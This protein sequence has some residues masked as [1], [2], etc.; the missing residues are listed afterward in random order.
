LNE[1]LLAATRGWWEWV[2]SV[3]LQAA[4]LCLIVAAVDRV[5]ARRAWPQL[6]AALWLTVILKLAVPPALVPSVTPPA[7][8][9]PGFLP[10]SDPGA[11]GPGV[12]LALF[13]LWILGAGISGL[14]CAWRWRGLQSRWLTPAPEPTPTWLAALA[15]ETAARLG[16][17]RTPDLRVERHAPGPAVVGFVRPVI[18]L[19]ARDVHRR[20]REDVRHALLHELAH[21][22]RRDPLLTLILLVAQSAFWF[23]PAVW[24]ARRRLG[25]L[26]E[27]ACDQL[28][29][30]ALG[31]TA[32]ARYRRTLLT[33][34]RP[35]L[36][37]PGG[38]L[39]FIRRRSELLERLRWLER[40]PAKPSRTR[41]PATVI[42][43]GLLLATGV[44]LAAPGAGAA[45]APE[46]E[47][48]AGCLR[49]RFSVL[50]LLAEERRAAEMGHHT[51]NR[52][53]IQP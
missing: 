44:S 22:R 35:L 15:G 27:V 49:L 40:A 36:S 38:L 42:L 29:V 7:F 24:I 21:L 31:P 12:L 43:C 16:L 48:S 20:R 14:A 37:S 46:P 6:L 51:T 53:E 45:L 28:A 47:S 11:S 13:A 2:S 1:V 5:L 3:S 41:R 10:G 8:L 34:A 32:A 23:H 50:A 33:F 52:Q 39:G 4:A 18:I 17:R 30:A 19:P 25:T 26:V 9:S